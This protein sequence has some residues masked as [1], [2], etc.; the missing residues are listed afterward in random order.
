MVA[1]EQLI[2]QRVSDRRWA[3]IETLLIFLLLAALGSTPPPAVN[4]AHYLAKAK[5]Y[6]DPT[7]CRGD[8]FLESADAHLVFYWTVG[9]LTFLLP[10]PAVAWVGRIVTWLLLAWSWQRLSA[11]LLPGRLYAVLTAGLFAMLIDR[12]HMAGEWVVGGVEAKGF[13]YVL[14]FLGL[15][16]VALG[17]WSRVWLLLGAASAFHVLVGGW[18]VVAAL[19]AWCITGDRQSRLMQIPYLAAGCV[20]ALPGVLPSAALTWGAEPEVTRQA[21]VIYVFERLSHHLVFHRLSDGVHSATHRPVDNMAGAVL[22]SARR[23]ATTSPRLVRS[24]RRT[25]RGNR[26][27]AGPV[28]EASSGHGRIAAQVLL[29]SALRRHVAGGRCA[30]GYVGDSPDC[31]TRASDGP[32]C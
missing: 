27:G 8:V 16:C 5:H 24:R 1:A 15:R 26:R 9:W 30:V 28:T 10:L 14:V 21:A 20:L 13:A 29:V 4:E 6:W 18:A 2:E 22:G 3:I 31:G 19:V 12:G 25:D 23:C 7:W 11:L 32:V 17:Q